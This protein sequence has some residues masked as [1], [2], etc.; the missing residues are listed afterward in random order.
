MKSTLN[1]MDKRIEEMESDLNMAREVQ[2]AFLE[3]Q[4]SRFPENISE[5]K[6]PIQFCHRYLPATTLAGDFFKIIPVSKHKVGILICDV[7]GHGAR[8]SLLTAYIQGLIGEIMP[9]APDPGAFME[10]LN[11][12]LNSIM[13][14]FTQGIFATAVYLV[15]DI[16]TGQILYTNAGHPRPL[17]L[18]RSQGAVE[19]L[20][21]NGN[22]TE[23]ALGLIEDFNYSVFEGR[24]KKD[25]TIFLYT[26]GVYEVDNKDGQIFGQKRLLNSIQSKLS[27]HPDQLLDGILNDMN[28]FTKS[29]VFRD[30]VC[31][32]TMHFGNV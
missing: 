26:D 11:T 17:I 16:K 2:M 7:M 30:D 27:N 12:G 22:E 32:V 1:D 23:P 20:Y 28:N 8:A 14:Q 9:A 6:S 18:R 29:D 15:A 10:R 31:M 21:T 24:T 3:K 25:D 13:Y 5:E 19:N 4:P